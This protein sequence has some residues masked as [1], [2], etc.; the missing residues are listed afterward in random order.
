MEFFMLIVFCFMAF[1]LSLRYQNPGFSA[2]AVSAIT[3]IVAFIGGYFNPTD[4]DRR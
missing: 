1:I 2:L 3:L 4:K